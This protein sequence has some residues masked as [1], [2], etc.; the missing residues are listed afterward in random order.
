MLKSKFKN[1]KL[2]LGYKSMIALAFFAAG[3]GTTVAFASIPSAGGQVST[4]YRNTLLLK[5]FRVIDAEAGQNCSGGETALTLNQ[6]GPQGAQ[7]ATGPQGPSGNMKNVSFYRVS[8]QVPIKIGDTS[9]YLLTGCSSLSDIAI[10]GGYGFIISPRLESPRP[11][12]HISTVTNS[13][14]AYQMGNNGLDFGYTWVVELNFDSY[15]PSIDYFTNL[16]VY[17]I[18]EHIEG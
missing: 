16:E 6:T 7:G 2:V 13:N 9:A 3:V 8:N 17:A 12:Q 18:C 1:F 14:G 15:Q 5:T 4:C 11:P 10:G